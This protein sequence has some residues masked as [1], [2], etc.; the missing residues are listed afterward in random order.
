MAASQAG[1]KPC[2]RH[3]CRAWSTLVAITRIVNLG[4]NSYRNH[5]VEQW[6]YQQLEVATLALWHNQSAMFKAILSPS[7]CLR[8]RDKRFL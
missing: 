8:S 3:W 4:R 1:I 5:G 2:S 6:G 7:N